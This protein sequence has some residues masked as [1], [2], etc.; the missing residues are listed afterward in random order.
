MPP[1]PKREFGEHTKAYNQQKS[2]NGRARLFVFVVHDLLFDRHVLELAGLEYL[3]TI[4][5]L[6]ELGVFV[7]RNDLNTRVLTLLIHGSARG[8]VGRLRLG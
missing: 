8:R 5:T 2:G 7:T 1:F 4:K 6:D 3:A